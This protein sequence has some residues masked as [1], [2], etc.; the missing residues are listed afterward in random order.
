ASQQKGSKMSKKIVVVGT[1]D[2]KGTEYKFVVDLLRGRGYRVITVNV[3]VMGSTNLFPIDIASEEVAR[4]GGMDLAEL[5]AANDRGK[6]IAVMSDGI[7]KVI[8]EL[9][10]KEAF[11][12]IIGMG[13]TAGTHIV[14]TA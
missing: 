9:Y 8:S 11:D 6:A 2:T 7:T 13:G 1:F 3:G 14:T 12:G 4:A 10:S 5:R